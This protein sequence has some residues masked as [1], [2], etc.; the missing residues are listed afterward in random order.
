MLTDVASDAFSKLGVIIAATVMAYTNED[1]RYY[2]DP[3]ASMVISLL[4]LLSSLPLMKSSGA[5]LLQVAPPRMDV[6]D[7]QDDLEMV[8]SH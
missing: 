6:K 8:S 2:A 1:K 3:A 7:I 5:I 4:I